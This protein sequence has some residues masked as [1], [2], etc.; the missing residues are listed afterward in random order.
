M[1]ELIVPLI[2]IF[3]GSYVLAEREDRRRA[4]M[5]RE[6]DW[7]MRNA[8]NRLLFPP[9]CMCGSCQLGTWYCEELDAKLCPSCEKK[10][11]ASRAAHNE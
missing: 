6:V 7:E 8:P 11:K 1:Y 4:E 2:L 10:I 5:H 3:V 9:Y